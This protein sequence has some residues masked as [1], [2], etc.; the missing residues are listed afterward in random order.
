MSI[1]PPKMPN[2][3]VMFGPNSA[4]ASASIIHTFEGAAHYIIKAIK[5]IQ[6]EYIKSM[7]C[8]PQALQNWLRHVDW[9]H[10]TTVLTANCRTWFK[11]NKADGRVI[12]SFP[13]SALASYRAWENPRWE[14]YEYVSWL[15]EDN[16]MSWLG[17]GFTHAERSMDWTNTTDYMD[18]EDESNVL[19]VD[20]PVFTSPKL[21]EQI[22]HYAEVDP[23]ILDASRTNGVG[24]STPSDPKVV[25]SNDTATSKVT[26]PNSAQSGPIPLP[27]T[28]VPLGEKVNGTA[29]PELNGHVEVTGPSNPTPVKLV[30]GEAEVLRSNM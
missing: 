30:S 6:R 23:G 21:H 14:D 11:R 19:L 18:W 17:N 4:P 22:Y 27:G 20:N 9:Q 15:P 1:N 8:K 25:G 10:S 16:N 5:K 29:E 24:E 13:G 28:E 26:G 7:V 2:M 12:T 3:F